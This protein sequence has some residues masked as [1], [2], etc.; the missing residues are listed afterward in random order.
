MPCQEEKKGWG[1]SSSCVT[2]LLTSFCSSRG[3]ASVSR[4]I[5]KEQGAMWAVINIKSN[6]PASENRF[7]PY[8][9]WNSRYFPTHGCWWRVKG[10]SVCQ[11]CSGLGYWMVGGQ[12]APA[13]PV[14][15]T[16]PNWNESPKQLSLGE[17]G[18]CAWRKVKVEA[19]WKGSQKPVTV[20]GKVYCLNQ[21][22]RW[23]IP[24]GAE[25]CRVSNSTSGLERLVA[26][27]KTRNG[28]GEVG[29]WVFFL[30]SESIRRSERLHC[31]PD[32]LNGNWDLC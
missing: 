29:G 17:W 19:G 3:R 18:S 4:V 7:S 22:V 23:L 13:K 16:I 8:S 10:V 28:R 5:Q 20:L 14:V 27:A 21:P 25:C 26:S 6:L 2:S 1:G 32:C 9:R 24:S 31:L 11:T 12:F 30:I 15:R